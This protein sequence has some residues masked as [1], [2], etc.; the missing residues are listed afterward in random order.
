MKV[1]VMAFLIA[2]ATFSTTAYTAV[3]DYGLVVNGKAIIF[4]EGNKPIN[5]NGRLLYPLR[6]VF[7]ALNDGNGSIEWNSGDRTVTIELRGIGM[8]LWADNPEAEI[9]GRKT[10]ILDGVAPVIHND[11]VYLPLRFVADRLGMNV[12]WNEAY[13]T[14]SVI[15]KN[16]YEAV[17]ALFKLLYADFENNVQKIS[18]DIK[19]KVSFDSAY[20][21]RGLDENANIDLT[22][23]ADIDIA[24]KSARMTA[25]MAAFDKITDF[26]VD[27][28]GEGLRLS[29]DDERQDAALNDLITVYGFDPSFAT[30]YP[31][32]ANIEKLAEKMGSYDPYLAFGFS[33]NNDGDYLARGL[34]YLSPEVMDSMAGTALMLGRTDNNNVSISPVRITYVFD[35]EMALK[36]M[37]IDYTLDMAEDVLG[38]RVA[39]RA[40]YKTSCKLVNS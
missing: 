26:E 36:T 34:L 5:I 27:L 30:G 13:S 37:D 4:E 24:N 32:I 29:I 11:R 14:A 39:M 6:D 20:A 19:T 9:N 28:S 12:G 18:L 10:P 21:F 8:K 1:A 3:P 40:Y 22:A 16:A 23:F 2:A 17:R 15:D 33:K 7:N 31:D 35:K 38:Q 25:S